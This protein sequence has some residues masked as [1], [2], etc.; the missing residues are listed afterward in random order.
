MRRALVLVLLLGLPLAA[1]AV[2]SLVGDGAWLRPEALLAR[3]D[4][5]LLAVEAEPVLAVAVFVAAYFVFSSTAMPF[6]P[7]MN[8]LAGYLFGLWIGAAAVLTAATSA[9]MLV[10]FLSRSTLGEGL[11]RRSS[12]LQSPLAAAIRRDAFGYVL[13]MRL[14]PMVPFFLVNVAAGA[15]GV[16]PRIFGIATL[17]GRIPATLIYV[18][19]GREAGR[20]TRLEDMMSPGVAATLLGLAALALL[21]IAWR[22]LRGRAAAE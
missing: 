6:G 1:V 7:A 15:V 16:K 11:L 12:V 3:R 22:H 20:I 14:V 19:L 8:L 2:A 13:A 21:P 10:F 9:A 17:L 18:N 5:L 4:A